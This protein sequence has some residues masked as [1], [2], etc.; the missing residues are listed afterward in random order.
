MDLKLQT[1][2]DCY[3]TSLMRK[4]VS[5]SLIGKML[6][7]SNVIVTEHYLS[8]LNPDELVEINSKLVTCSKS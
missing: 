6:N 4:N 3:A 5:T 8:G 1:A 7:H 2:R